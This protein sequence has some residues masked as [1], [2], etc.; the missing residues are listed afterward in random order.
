MVC[1]EVHTAT[2]K[3]HIL[4]AQVSLFFME[5]GGYSSFI[6]EIQV[7]HHLNVQCSVVNIL[8]IK[9]L[10][11]PF[12]SFCP[13]KSIRDLKI[14]L[15]A[16]SPHLWQFSRKKAP[17]Y[18]CILPST[19]INPGIIKSR[20]EAIFGGK[21]HPPKALCLHRLDSCMYIFICMYVHIMEMK[22]GLPF[23]STHRWCSYSMLCFRSPSRPLSCFLLFLN[24]L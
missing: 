14:S 21:K 24:N 17:I 20:L 10:L 9:F 16:G 2:C 15:E 13:G 18:C 8:N 23:F 19:L 1:K 22:Y 5:A 6:L 7:C 11:K 3:K 4:K 12:L